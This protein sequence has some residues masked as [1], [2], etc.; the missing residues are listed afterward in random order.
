MS[1]SHSD[2]LRIWLP[3]IRARSGADVFVER[4]AEGLARAGHQALVQWFSHRFEQAPG[5]LACSRPPGPVDLVHA[6]SWS[7]Y[8]FRR[9]GLPLLVTEH[10]FVLDPALAP[11]R[12]RAQAIYHRMRIGPAILRSYRAADR[13]VAVSRHTCDA[14][15]EH[16]GLAA[17][18]IP[19]WIDAAGYCKD[20]AESRVPSAGDAFRLLFVGNPTPRKGGDLLPALAA[21]LGPD[22]EI[23]WLGL[24]NGA[25]S[26]H[27]WP[28]TIRVH[29]AVGPDKMFE[30]YRRCDAVL[31]LSRYEA[32]GY[33][34]LEAMACARP[35]IGFDCTGTA[36]ICIQDQTALLAP[37]DDLDGIV[38]AC[39]RLRAEPALAA[40]LGRAGR[41]RAMERFSVQLAIARYVDCY[42]SLVRRN[43][44]MND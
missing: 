2:R 36:E 12:S 13:V 14:I 15:V 17:E 24:R 11:Y 42:R 44:S 28:E 39:R 37:V 29:P 16:T 3:S 18:T 35:V 22:F 25:R 20:P 33:A 5:L 30:W 32:F 21:R 1:A 34:A 27:R 10:H 43:G 8:A 41:A 4:L 6:N 7:G 19:N 26:A 38:H 23:N 40:T 9:R 31:V